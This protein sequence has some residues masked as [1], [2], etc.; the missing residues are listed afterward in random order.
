MA[1]RTTTI[2]TVRSNVRAVHGDRFR[3]KS[4]YHSQKIR[5]YKVIIECPICENTREIG[6][7]HLLKGKTRCNCT[8]P[9][10]LKER[11]KA[12]SRQLYIEPERGLIVGD[13]L[14]EYIRQCIEY[15]YPTLAGSVEFLYMI[16]DEMINLYE[17]KGA[18]K[19]TR[20][21]RWYTK[22]FYNTSISKVC[23]QCVSGRLLY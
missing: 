22:E 2:E 12:Y 21:G 1:G 20:C 10:K 14:L 16:E 8:N 11:A 6:Y 19:C 5:D 23:K 9:S 13:E 7:R 18:R 17:K 15:D 3:V 4:F